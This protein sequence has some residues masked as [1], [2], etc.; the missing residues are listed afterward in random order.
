MQSHGGRYSSA[1]THSRYIYEQKVGEGTYGEVF[2]VRSLLTLTLTPFLTFPLFF[3]FFCRYPL[4]FFATQRP[5]HTTNSHSHTQGRDTVTM[6][7][8]AVKKI[9]TNLSGSGIPQTE[10]R[11]VSILKSLKHKNVVRL[12]NVETETDKLLLV[13]ECCECDLRKTIKRGRFRGWKLKSMVHQMLLGLQYCHDHRIIHR[14]LKPHNILVLNGVLKISDFGLARAFQVP[15]PA[16]T[17]EIV[18]L[19]YRAPEVLLGE[20]R[21]SPAVDLW[22]CGAIMS[23]MATQLPLFEA[24]CEVMELYRI[25][26]LLG[27]PDE[28]VWPGVTSLPDYKP[29]FPTWR[30][31]DLSTVL[32]EACADGID[33]LDQML[34]MDPHRRIT[35]NGAVNVCRLYIKIYYKLKKIEFLISIHFSHQKK[36]KIHSTRGLTSSSRCPCREDL[37][38]TPPPSPSFPHCL[39]FHTLC[40]AFM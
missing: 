27:T 9:R 26:Q 31:K 37:V 40:P 32:P 13:F 18:T 15:M 2:K 6:Q 24:D 16:Y 34:T 39:F 5:H 10:L 8:V 21:Y 35:A 1:P 23:E 3:F 22:S 17:H 25:F 12:L 30:K 14:D 19:W 20:E 11:E 33:L 7:S 36:I 4:L 38:H 29:V 28:T